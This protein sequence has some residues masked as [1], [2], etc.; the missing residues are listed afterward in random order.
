MIDDE[1]DAVFASYLIRIEPNT[2]ILVPKFLYYFFQSSYYW[3]AIA[4]GIS[5]SAQGGFNASKLQAMRVNF[6]H[7]KNSQEDIV[8]RIGD[9]ETELY[10]RANILFIQSARISELRISLLSHAFTREK[11]VA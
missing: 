4:D 9:F 2:D 7:D 1:V 11:A 10:L 8:A 5:G 3:D 6:P